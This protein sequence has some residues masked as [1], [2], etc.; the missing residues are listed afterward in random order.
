LIFVLID[1]K[2]P[3]IQQTIR[4]KVQEYMNRAEKLKE[5]LEKGGPKQAVKDGGKDMQFFC[6]YLLVS[7]LRFCSNIFAYP[8]FSY[9]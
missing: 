2:S 4:Q 3:K 5:F 1:E 8:S 7:F 9:Y 6:S